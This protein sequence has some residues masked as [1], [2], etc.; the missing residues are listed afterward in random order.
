MLRGAALTGRETIF[1]DSTKGAL[2]NSSHGPDSDSDEDVDVAEELRQVRESLSD[3]QTAIS[4]LI[5]EQRAVRGND[6]LGD[7][8][9]DASR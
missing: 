3:V 5:D 2:D 1:L 4:T 7:V 9:K 8:I 6:P